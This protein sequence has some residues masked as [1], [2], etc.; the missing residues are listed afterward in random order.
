M[1]TVGIGNGT[2]DKG[3]SGSAARATAVGVGAVEDR[4]GAVGVGQ[5]QVRVFLVFICSIVGELGDRK[6]GSWQVGSDSCLGPGRFCVTPYRV[7]RRAGPTS[8]GGASGT[9]RSS[10][11]AGTK[12][13]LIVPRVVLGPCFFGPCLVP[14]IVPGPFENL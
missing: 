6:M 4:A 12:H 8:R 7:V 14:L 2:E 3:E 10:G 5:E 13:Y 9:K 11:R 1:G